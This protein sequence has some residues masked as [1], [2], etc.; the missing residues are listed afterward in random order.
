M[1]KSF[2]QIPPQSTGKKLVTEFRKEIYYRNQVRSILIN[3]TVTGSLSGATGKVS[4]IV[5]EG[6]AEGSGELYL[7]DFTGSF[8]ANEMLQVNGLDFA[9]V[10]LASGDQLEF[11]IQKFTICDPD[12]PEINQRIDRFGASVTTFTD[13]SPIFGSFGTLSVG[14]PQIVKFYRFSNDNADILW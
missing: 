4:G 5:T 13:G 3:D 9:V 2:I 7:K 8:T 11:D 12:N 14:E 10:D 6:F 1:S